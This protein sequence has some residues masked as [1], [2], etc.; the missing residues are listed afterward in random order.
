MVIFFV[1]FLKKKS[2]DVPQVS[3]GGEKVKGRM[4]GCDPLCKVFEVGYC[5]APKDKLVGEKKKK[6]RSL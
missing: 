6:N 5:C 3:G 2:E 1:F 4:P